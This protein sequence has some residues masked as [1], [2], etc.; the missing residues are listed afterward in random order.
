MCWHAASSHPTTSYCPH[1]R[2]GHARRCSYVPAAAAPPDVFS[3]R[4]DSERLQPLAALGWN[5]PRSSPARAHQLLRN[6]RGMDIDAL[7]AACAGPPR[8]AWLTFRVARC[9]CNHVEVPILGVVS[10]GG[11]SVLLLLLRPCDVAVGQAAR[12]HN[13]HAFYQQVYCPAPWLPDSAASLAREKVEKTATTCR[14][15]GRR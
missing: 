5:C 8:H 11:H 2:R 12:P 15:Q 14:L 10:Q 6:L 1:R 4:P 3:M 9:V 13:S 7:R